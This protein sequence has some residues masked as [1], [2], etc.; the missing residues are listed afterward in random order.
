MVAVALQLTGQIGKSDWNSQL[1]WD[2]SQ[3]PEAVGSI[4]MTNIHEKKGRTS[5][6]ANYVNRPAVE[7]RI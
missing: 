6:P 4:S 2:G 7:V 1:D 5:S 3:L